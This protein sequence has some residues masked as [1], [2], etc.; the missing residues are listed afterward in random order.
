M[1]FSVSLICLYCVMRQ[2]AGEDAVLRS[3]GIGPIYTLA[4]R[5]TP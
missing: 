1:L 5:K 3:E 4:K 2:T